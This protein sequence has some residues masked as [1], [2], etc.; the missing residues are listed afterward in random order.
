MNFFLH[1]T[2]EIFK[3]LINENPLRYGKD[4]YTY[5]LPEFCANT[6]LHEEFVSNVA[7]QSAEV[8]FEELTYFCDDVGCLDYKLQDCLHDLVLQADQINNVFKDLIQLYLNVLLAQLRKDAKSACK[9]K[10][11]SKKTDKGQQT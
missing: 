5:C 1:L 8:G 10:D 11:G 7:K 3:H 6:Q 2:T 4:L 9:K